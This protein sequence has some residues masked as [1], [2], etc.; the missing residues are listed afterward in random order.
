[1]MTSYNNNLTKD[2]EEFCLKHARLIKSREDFE[3]FC[4]FV[5]F[6]EGACNSGCVL[7]NICQTYDKKRGKSLHQVK[8][9]S[10]PLILASFRKEKLEKL[11]K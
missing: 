7:Y 6:G 1:M 9:E 4:D 3:V 11:L 2:F 5:G 8:E 10:F